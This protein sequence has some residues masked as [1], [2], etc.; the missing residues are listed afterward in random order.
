MNYFF[1]KTLAGSVIRGSVIRGS[2]YKIIKS[3]EKANH[4]H[5]LQN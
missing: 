2:V 1:Q 4:L 5:Y 3:M